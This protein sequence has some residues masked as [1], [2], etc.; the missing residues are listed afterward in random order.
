MTDCAVAPVTWPGPNPDSTFDPHAAL[1]GMNAI[2][3]AAE[4]NKIASNSSRVPPDQLFR[5]EVRTLLCVSCV[6]G[7]GGCC[8]IHRAE[9]TAVLCRGGGGCGLLAVLSH[10]CAG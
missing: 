6:G 7:G 10:R 3:R 1:Q 8:A 4:A 9:L 5:S 2:H